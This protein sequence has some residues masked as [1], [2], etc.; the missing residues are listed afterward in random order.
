MKA[1]MRATKKIAVK[2]REVVS[3]APKGE[4]EFSSVEDVVKYFKKNPDR[5]TDYVEM[6]LIRHTSIAAIHIAQLAGMVKIPLKSGSDTYTALPATSF[7]KP[8][9]FDNIGMILGGAREMFP[10]SPFLV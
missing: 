3:G 10:S 6:G 5:L 4:L 8:E 1:M 2:G 9:R 7:I